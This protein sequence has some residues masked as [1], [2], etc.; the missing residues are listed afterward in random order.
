MCFID[1]LQNEKEQTF[2][3]LLAIR[4]VSNFTISLCRLYSNT[5][6]HNLLENR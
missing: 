5:I 6:L 3:T 4:Q 2:T 1:I